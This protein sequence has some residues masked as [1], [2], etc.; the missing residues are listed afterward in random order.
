MGP[1]TG[2]AMVV[3][4]GVFSY[5]GFRLLTWLIGLF[6]PAQT[7]AAGEGGAS[8]ATQPVGTW[9]RFGDWLVSIV[10][11]FKPPQRVPLAFP[12]PACFQPLSGKVAPGEDLICPWCRTSFQTP[13]PPLAAPPVPKKVFKRERP[14]GSLWGFFRIIS[15]VCGFGYVALLFSLAT[16]AVLPREARVLWMV[17][18]A[19]AGAWVLQALFRRFWRKETFL[20][21]S[22][23]GVGGGTVLFQEILRVIITVGFP[24][25]VLLVLFL[26]GGCLTGI[27]GVFLGFR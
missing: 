20:P 15:I 7:L 8:L 14:R 10:W 6:F 19:L 16:F 24:I 12:C 27:V 2:L 17:L 26:G 25:A 22:F 11:P 4:M 18:G 1:V 13:E 9:T 21:K 5:Q 3:L 23:R